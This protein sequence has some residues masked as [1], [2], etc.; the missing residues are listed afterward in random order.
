MITHIT[1]TNIIYEAEKRFINWLLIFNDLSL[2]NLLIGNGLVNKDFWGENYLQPPHNT[3]LGMA[4]QFGVVLSLLFLYFY[5]R[6]IL[7]Y[8]RLFIP[9]A[10][11]TIMPMMVLDLFGFRLLWLFLAVLLIRTIDNHDNHF[12]KKFWT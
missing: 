1:Q 3:L 8:K 11:L 7:P 12:Y 2:S 9:I 6:L 4:Y 10:F 5:I